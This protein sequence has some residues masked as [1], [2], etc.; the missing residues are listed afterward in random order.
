M[1][2]I[3]KQKFFE[4]LQKGESIEVY[5]KALKELW[6]SIDH[7]YMTR[8]I[9]ERRLMIMSKDYQNAKATHRSIKLQNYWEEYEKGEKEIYTLNPER[10]FRTLEDRYVNRHVKFL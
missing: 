3:T 4:A 10:D 9:E 7:E 5:E 1:M 6:G 2:M 8:A